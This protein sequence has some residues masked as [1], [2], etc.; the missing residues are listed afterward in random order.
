MPLKSINLM[1][2]T[3]GLVG[4]LGLIFTFRMFLVELQ[5]H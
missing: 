5:L 2:A 4:A 1:N 3:I